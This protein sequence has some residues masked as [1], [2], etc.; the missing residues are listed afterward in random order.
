MPIAG[1]QRSVSTAAPTQTVLLD[2]VVLMMTLV[3][4]ILAVPSAFL[5]MQN[6]AQELHHPDLRTV[7]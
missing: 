3:V 7:I 2:R 1:T 6:V 4:A 5:T